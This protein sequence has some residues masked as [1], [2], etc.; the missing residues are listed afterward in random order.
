M[1]PVIVI[2]HGKIARELVKMAGVLAGEQSAV[3]TLEIAASS[4]IE[5]V[6]DEVAGL[7]AG[8]ENAGDFGGALI[9]TDMLGGSSCNVCV[10]FAVNHRV[11]IVSGVNLYMLLSALKN[12]G[13]LPLEELK[14]RVIADGVKSIADVCD[15]F[16]K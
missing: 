10:P 6:K 11:A 15:I 14:I 3:D 2:S 12:R 9:L 13:G 7:L 4:T 1:I 5:S 8:Y 16:I